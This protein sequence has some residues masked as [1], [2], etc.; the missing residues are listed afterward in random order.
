LQQVVVT[1]Y[2]PATDDPILV[3]L[4]AINWACDKKSMISFC[5][6]YYR[7]RGDIPPT[8]MYGRYAGLQLSSYLSLVTVSVGLDKAVSSPCTK[9]TFGLIVLSGATSPTVPGIQKRLRY[10]LAKALDQCVH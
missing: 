8:C 6:K 9:Y 4:G 5:T 1:E 10:F 7:A 3:I 2:G